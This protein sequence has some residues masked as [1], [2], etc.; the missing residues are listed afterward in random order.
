M[1]SGFLNLI[2]IINN[3][4]ISFLILT[5]LPDNFIIIYI[6][7]IF[8]LILQL[9]FHILT[10]GFVSEFT[11]LLKP[12]PTFSWLLRY[13]KVSFIS[14]PSSQLLTFSSCSSTNINFLFSIILNLPLL[15]FLI[16]TIT[17]F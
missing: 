13:F 15:L 4:F 10:S 16:F 2:N 12:P 9:L 5:S 8:F 1:I 6:T 7:D 17:N 11:G 3:I 14:L